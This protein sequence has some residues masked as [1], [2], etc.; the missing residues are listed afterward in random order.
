MIKT[1]AISIRNSIATLAQKIGITPYKEV[2]SIAISTDKII[3]A[4]KYSALAQFNIEDEYIDV[5]LFAFCQEYIINVL[6]KQYIDISFQ[7]FVEGAYKRRFNPQYMSLILDNFISNSEKSNATKFIVKM[8]FQDGSPI[9]KAID[10]GNGFGNADLCKIFEF[11]ISNTGGTG[12]GLYNIKRAVE[13]MN[14]LIKAQKND[15]NGATFI[16]SF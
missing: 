13:R 3:S 16:I 10:D 15:M 1:N 8:Y 14:G 4:L 9:I 7:V 2:G 11:G 5:D 12:I 6:E